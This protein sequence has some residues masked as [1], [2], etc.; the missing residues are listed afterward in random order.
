MNNGGKAPNKLS[1]ESGILHIYSSI[2][3]YISPGQHNII[4]TQVEM[5]PPKDTYLQIINPEGSQS[6]TVTPA[7]IYHAT[8]SLIQI[9][10]KNTTDQ[11]IAINKGDCIGR[12]IY[13]RMQ[14]SDIM[15]EDKN[16]KKQKEYIQVRKASNRNVIL[17]MITPDNPIYHVI[18]CNENEID[19]YKI[20][21]VTTE[22]EIPYDIALSSD[23]M[24]NTIDILIPVT[25]THE[26]LGLIVNNNPDIGNRIQLLECQKST[27]VARIPTWRSMLRHAFMT[28]IQGTVINSVQDMKT[29]ITNA[30]KHLNKIITCQFT[31]IIKQAMHP[32]E[33]IPLLY[34]DQ[35][36]IISK[37]LTT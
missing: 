30:R 20:F 5:T 17:S 31:I 10:I 22:I 18:P 28:N 32:Q 13:Q 7:T 16:T 6:F 25:G 29:C 3:T 2:T 23:P 34:H 26:T 12:I 19:N 9:E 15:I 27:P 35:M 4:P 37:I 21:T 8:N 36:N 11:N 24:D 1:S 33:V 14:V